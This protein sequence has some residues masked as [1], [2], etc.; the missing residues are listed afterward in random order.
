[1]NQD[2]IL[3]GSS[4][5]SLRRGHGHRWSCGRSPTPI[6]IVPITLG[7]RLDAGEAPAQLA[8]S[9][10]G[11]MAALD[12]ALWPNSGVR[13]VPRGAPAFRCL[14]QLCPAPVPPVVPLAVLGRAR[15]FG[16]SRLRVPLLSRRVSRF[17]A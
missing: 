10:A 1:M 6:T 12:A 17:S 11:I 5:G 8:A 15:R 14:G 7:R 9:S 2:R 16:A 4:T 3:I 13:T